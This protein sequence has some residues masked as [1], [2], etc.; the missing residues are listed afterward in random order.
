MITTHP[1]SHVLLADGQALFGEALR[2]LFS[3]AA[4]DVRLT[5]VDTLDALRTSA[6]QSFDL[7]LVDIGLPGLKGVRGVAMLRDTHPCAKIVTIAG[8]CR[9]CDLTLAKSLGIDGYV[10]K[11]ESADAL[12][13]SIR[14]VLSGAC[15]VPGELL[16]GWSKAPVLARLAAGETEVLRLMCQGVSD[17]SIA[18]KL[19]MERR[20]VRATIRE[21]SMKFGAANRTEAVVRAIA[22][23][24]DLG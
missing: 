10:L 22:E 16:N 8:E 11:T 17:Q 24:F 19:C 15:V 21:I 6:A 2:A 20:A 3:A 4:P 18:Y 1:Q 14:Q 12:L 23:G 9:R 7:V 13:R 5:F